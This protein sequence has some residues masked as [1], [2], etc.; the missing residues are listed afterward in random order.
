MCIPHPAQVGLPHDLH[1]TLRHIPN[2]V[3]GT[4]SLEVNVSAKEM[5]RVTQ[6]H[7]RYAKFLRTVVHCGVY[8][9]WCLC[10]EK[11]SILINLIKCVKVSLSRVLNCHTT[12]K[13]TNSSNFHCFLVQLATA[14]LAS[15]IAIAASLLFSGHQ[16]TMRSDQHN[17]EQRDK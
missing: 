4:A 2:D 8:V 3:N 5:E 13:H 16:Q 1:V 15:P 6:L 17:Q 12:T 7:Y 14:L 11:G 10:Y 9:W